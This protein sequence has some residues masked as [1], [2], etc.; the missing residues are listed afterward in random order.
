[1][2]INSAMSSLILKDQIKPDDLQSKIDDDHIDRLISSLRR[3]D[4]GLYVYD[5]PEFGP[6][7]FARYSESALFDNGGATSLRLHRFVSRG[8]QISPLTALEM[9]RRLSTRT[10]SRLKAF[11]VEEAS[12]VVCLAYD[13]PGEEEWDF[14]FFVGAGSRKAA[15]DLLSADQATA[16]FDDS[17]P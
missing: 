8:N 14:R 12:S 3:Y 9:S 10:F 6:G 17:T 11:G 2:Q 7:K 15:F 1:M 5:V 16:S 4:N 13:E